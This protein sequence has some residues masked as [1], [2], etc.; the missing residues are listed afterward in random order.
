MDVFSY[1]E[2]REIILS[3][4][5]SKDTN[6]SNQN[7]LSFSFR[8]LG[9]LFEKKIKTWW[10][11]VSFEHYLLAQIIPRRLRWD[12]PPNDGLFDDQSNKEWFNFFTDKGFELLTMLLSRKQWK[13]IWLESQIKEITVCIEVHKDSTEFLQL[14]GELKYKLLKWDKETQDKKWK[15]FLRDLND[16]DGKQVFKWQSFD[17]SQPVCSEGLF[18][19]TTNLAPSVPT[20]GYR[21]QDASVTIPNQS[22]DTPIRSNIPRRR[23]HGAPRSR[24]QS[25]GRGNHHPYP[26]PIQTN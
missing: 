19:D 24:G 16:F 13:K 6:C 2:N 20:D 14:S 18:K 17:M 15:K 4:V 25:Q 22:H 21:T 7:D 1:L 9:H 12:L 23:G 3:D 8:K 5:F 11:I 10:D 26:A